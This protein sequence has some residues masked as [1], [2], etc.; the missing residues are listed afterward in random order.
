MDR[1][2]SESAREGSSQSSLTMIMWFALFMLKVFRFRILGV[3]SSW[4]LTVSL[5]V[6]VAPESIIMDVCLSVC[7][8]AAA[9]EKEKE[10]FCHA[11]A[12]V[13]VSESVLSFVPPLGACK[14]ILRRIFQSTPNAVRKLNYRRTCTEPSVKCKSACLMDVTVRLSDKYSLKLCGCSFVCLFGCGEQRDTCAQD[15]RTFVE[16]NR[17]P[18]STYKQTTC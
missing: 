18:R 14:A 11:C 8:V 5:F 12:F 15:P 7:C 4:R 13:S 9:E 16:G 1:L 2:E 6:A 17:T 3:I 10:S